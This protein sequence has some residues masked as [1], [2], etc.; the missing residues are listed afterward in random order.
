LDSRS[1]RVP[2]CIVDASST[3]DNLRKEKPKIQSRLLLQRG[4]KWT[5]L[6]N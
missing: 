2:K 3:S 5:Y 6:G 4:A 1:V